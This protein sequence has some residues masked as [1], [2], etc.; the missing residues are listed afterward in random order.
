MLSILL[1]TGVI[2]HHGDKLWTYNT[3]DQLMTGNHANAEKFQNLYQL[4]IKS[5]NSYWR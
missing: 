4:I 1:I 5:L 3:D 2:N